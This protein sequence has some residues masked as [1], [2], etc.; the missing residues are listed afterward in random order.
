MLRFPSPVRWPDNHR[1]RVL[2]Q[3]GVAGFDEMLRND[4]RPAMIG[5]GAVST[6]TVSASR[7]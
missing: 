5:A 4:R 6:S 3:A 7:D 2:P 1:H